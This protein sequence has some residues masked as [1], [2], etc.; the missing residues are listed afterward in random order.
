M[1]FLQDHASYTC[2]FFNYGPLDAICLFLKLRI[3]VN[4]LG[5]AFWK[6][7]EDPTVEITLIL[8]YKDFGLTPHSPL[9]FAVLGVSPSLPDF[10]V[11]L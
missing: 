4:Y 11:L 3:I 9:S 2:L 6:K 8:E 10:R 5:E 1:N 7:I